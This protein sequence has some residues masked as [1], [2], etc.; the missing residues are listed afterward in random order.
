MLATA[1]FVVFGGIAVLALGWRRAVRGERSGV[2]LGELTARQ[3]VVSFVAVPAVG[4]TGILAI[5]VV[6]AALR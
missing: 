4:L 6:A 5:S 2:V 3:T 1:I